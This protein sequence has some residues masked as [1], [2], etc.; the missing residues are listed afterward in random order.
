MLVIAKVIGEYPQ[1]KWRNPGDKFEFAGTKPGLWMEAVEKVKA[2][3][4]ADVVDDVVV[5]KTEVTDEESFASVQAIAA[6]EE[7]GLT[8]KDIKG[9]GS[10]G[11]ITSADVKV[12]IAAKAE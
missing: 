9:T 2:E 12:A 11:K 1:G 6:A 10:E 7:A 3:V 4:K 8:S 5:V